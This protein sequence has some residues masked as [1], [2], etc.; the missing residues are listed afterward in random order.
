MLLARVLVHGQPSYGWVD[1]PRIRLLDGA[2]FEGQAQDTGEEL[3][4][5]DV[6]LLTPVVPSKI[7]AVGRNFAEH[8]AEMKMEV[9]AQPSVFIKPNT[10]LV[11]PGGTVVLP[12]E[13]VSNEVE[14]EAELVIVMGRTARGVSVDDALDYVFGY[15]CAND[16][17]ARDLQ[18]S[19]VHVTRGKGY[20][21]FCPLG[22]W[23][24][25]GLDPSAIGIRCRVNGELRQDGNTRDLIFDV[26][27]LISHLSSWTTLLPGDVI[28][29]GSPAGT[30][31]LRDG[32]RV[33]IELEGIGILEHLV[34][35]P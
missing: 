4:L 20:D 11:D 12:P 9:P 23:V 17:S 31:P 28:L 32:D 35:A 16:V 6:D 18:R 19:D 25:T 33:E 8:I 27:T 30:G 26:P 34:T 21:T 7:L 22:P 5:A 1:G 24:A 14:H 15:T 2:P 29:T 13:E 3:L 10:T